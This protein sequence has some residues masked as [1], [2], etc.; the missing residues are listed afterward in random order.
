MVPREQP[1]GVQVSRGLSNSARSRLWAPR[2]GR[3]RWRVDCQQ[4]GDE[5]A[6]T[7]GNFRQPRRVSPDAPFMTKE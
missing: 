4:P 6:A 7:L 5:R 1:S 2:G 3:R